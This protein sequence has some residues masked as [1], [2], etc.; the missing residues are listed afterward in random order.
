[1]KSDNLNVY[2]YIIMVV[3]QDAGKILESE[4]SWFISQNQL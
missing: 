2:I 4:V 1:M 3:T